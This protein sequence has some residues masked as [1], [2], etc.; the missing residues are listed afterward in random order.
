MLG[1]EN[2]EAGERVWGVVGPVRVVRVN[3]PQIFWV[4]RVNPPPQIFLFKGCSCVVKMFNFTLF[5][6]VT[7]ILAQRSR[8][9]GS[10][11]LKVARTAILRRLVPGNQGT[12][13]AHL[14][15]SCAECQVT[16]DQH[17]G[18]PGSTDR[19][20][21]PGCVWAR[22]SL[23]LQSFPAL[24]RVRQHRPPHSHK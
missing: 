15:T 9:L 4:T 8:E 6:L 10:K 5:T 20:T 22:P 1:D 11:S 14:R 19:F 18:L 17:S 24:D 7:V 13:H 3:T 16:P 2:R 21:P 23:L 12:P